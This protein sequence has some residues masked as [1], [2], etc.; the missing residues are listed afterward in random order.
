MLDPPGEAD[1]FPDHHITRVPAR[2]PRLAAWP[3][4]AGGPLG[5]LSPAATLAV[6]YAAGL[7]LTGDHRAVVGLTCVSVAVSFL[8]G[9]P[10]GAAAAILIARLPF[11][12]DEGRPRELADFLAAFLG[13]TLLTLAVAG[14]AFS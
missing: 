6:G 13:G 8:L 11:F 10:A 5:A 4:M 9:W 7:W 1:S 2:R 3:A 12:P 14:L